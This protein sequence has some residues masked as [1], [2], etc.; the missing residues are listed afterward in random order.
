V[1]NLRVVPPASRKLRRPRTHLP[2]TASLWI[3]R[4]AGDPSQRVGT[5]EGILVERSGFISRNPMRSPMSCSA[6]GCTAIHIDMYTYALLRAGV[7]VLAS[8]HCSIAG[9]APSLLHISARNCLDRDRS[10]VIDFKWPSIQRNSIRQPRQQPCWVSRKRPSRTTAERVV[11]LVL[12]WRPSAS[13]RRKNGESADLRFSGFE[14][15]GGSTL[16][17]TGVVR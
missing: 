9:H 5:L 13:A 12:S 7:S 14:P 6:Y 3:T 16:D 10:S 2:A 15:I 11:S 8:T 4:L 17:D 1:A